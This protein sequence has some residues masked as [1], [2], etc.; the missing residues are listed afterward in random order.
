MLS[1]FF[2]VIPDLTVL[3]VVIVYVFGHVGPWSDLRRPELQSYGPKIIHD[4]D[5]GRHTCMGPFSKWSDSNQRNS[6]FTSFYIIDGS[7]IVT[8]LIYLIQHTLRQTINRKRRRWKYQS[9]YI[10]SL[11]F[12]HPLL[13]FFLFQ[14]RFFSSYYRESSW[15]IKREGDP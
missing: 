13:L 4:G 9:R 5:E 11:S 3:W 8:L 15:M 12:R 14:R 2:F 1:C 6:Y 7:V 10:G